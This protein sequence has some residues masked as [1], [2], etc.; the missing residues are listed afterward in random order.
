MSKLLELVEIAN[1]LYRDDES[2]ICLDGSYIGHSSHLNTSSN[3]RYKFCSIEN[4]KPEAYFY[5]DEK[6][7]TL[8]N[9]GRGIG[10]IYRKGEWAK[11]EDGTIPIIK[12]EELNYEIY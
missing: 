10:L 3:S 12:Q 8:A 9:W 5:Y 2:L 11:R 1:T 7:D 4:T 6:E